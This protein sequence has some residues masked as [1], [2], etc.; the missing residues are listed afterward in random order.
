MDVSVAHGLPARLGNSQHDAL[1]R[2]AAPC[3]FY[4]VQPSNQDK[5]PCF[6]SGYKVCLIEGGEDLG[7]VVLRPAAQ[8]IRLQTTEAA[9]GVCNTRPCFV[10]IDC[11][12]RGVTTNARGCEAP[13]LVRVKIR[14]VV[15]DNGVVHASSAQGSFP[16]AG[17]EAF[18]FPHGI[19]HY[20]SERGISPDIEHGLTITGLFRGRA[21]QLVPL[22]NRDQGPRGIPVLPAQG[23]Y[24][25]HIAWL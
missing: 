9:S 7:L 21:S 4:L 15:D 6:I 20:S 11:M 5:I 23:G 14:A 3:S 24:P 16:G 1:V 12:H 19:K 22:V 13:Y 25:N 17:Q 2:H 10:P 18:L 8:E